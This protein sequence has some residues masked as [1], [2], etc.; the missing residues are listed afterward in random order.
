MLAFDEQ[1]V[2]WYWCMFEFKCVFAWYTI[3]HDTMQMHT[4]LIFKCTLMTMTHG[5]A[6][7]FMLIE[8]MERYRV[9]FGR[10]GRT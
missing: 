1:E 5:S 9:G 7:I 6:L 4:R 8:Y 10:T 2:R 3:H